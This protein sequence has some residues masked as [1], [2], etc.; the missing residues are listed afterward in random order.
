MPR[1][2]VDDGV[3]INYHLDDFRNPWD[4][5]KGE[6]ILIHHGSGENSKFNIPLAHALSRRYR[7]L[8]I[9]ARGRGESS[10]PPEGR[11]LSGE[12]DDAVSAGDR[13]VK[14]ALSLMDQL[15]IQKVH[16]LGVASGG[17]IGVIF[18]T[19]HPDRVRSLILC[20]SPYRVPDELKS[21]WSLGEKDVAT[22]IEKLGNREWTR[23]SKVAADVLDAPKVENKMEAWSRAQREK[24]P[25]H[26]YASF[27]KWVGAFDVR[28][29]LAQIKVPTLILASKRS[30][31]MTLE[32]QR[33]VQ[34]QIPNS[35]LINF[36]EPAIHMTI[37]DR[38]AEAV[39]NF[40][41]SIE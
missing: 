37:P 33:F 19:S 16:W 41:Q 14:D 11:T 20:N 38:C 23:R 17:V 35:K 13:C 40:V 10:A 25:T 7:V 1:V 34:R 21:R 8:R 18:A 26:A 27:F 31:V 30:F 9:D 24:I 29:R 39:L 12:L 32:E 15:G 36:E 2:T 28:G 6:T 22:A 5:E 3:E 4:E